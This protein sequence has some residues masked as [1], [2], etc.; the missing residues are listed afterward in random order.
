MK[1]LV[2]Y[3]LVNQ[4]SIPLLTALAPNKNNFMN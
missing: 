2:Y 1:L 3:N 4:F